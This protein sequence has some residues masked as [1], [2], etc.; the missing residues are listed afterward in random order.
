MVQ[1]GDVRIFAI[2]ILDSSRALQKLAAESGG[3]AFRV[4]KLEDLEDAAARVS[5]QLHSEYVLGYVAKARARDGMYRK[6]KVETV[7]GMTGMP[8]H[9][10]WRHGYYGPA[11]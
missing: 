7:T 1:E 9:T 6:L 8:L 5:E 3:R 2:S 11:E 4:R 10:T